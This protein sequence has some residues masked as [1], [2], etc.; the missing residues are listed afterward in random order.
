MASIN[1]TT[2][3]GIV[4]TADNK[5]SL[6]WIHHPDHT[7][8][9]S[10]GYIGVSTNTKQR[11]T[12]HKRSKYNVHLFEAIKKYGWDNLIK[13]ILVVSKEDYCLML[14]NKLRIDNN[15]GWNIV[16]GG[17]KPP[18]RYGN[19]DRLGIPGWSKGLKLSEEHK[20]NL[21]ES[22]LGQSP[23]NK[24]LKGFQKAW[25]KGV[26]MAEKSKEAF[27]VIVTCPHCNKVG[28]IAGMR[29]WH[30]DNCKNKDIK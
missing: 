6:Y 10:Q 9:F 2:S 27:R 8:I 12:N 15:I 18:L 3:S 16:K 7:D 22:H 1:A 4:T 14:E 13:T 5:C 21:R 19:K 11:F 29:T 30:M 28:K 26:A 17:G 20:K 23:W 24:G 25:N